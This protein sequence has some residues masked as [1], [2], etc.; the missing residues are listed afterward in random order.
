MNSLRIALFTYSTKPRG[1]VIHTLELA[2]ALHQLGHE[3]TV[4]ALDKDGCGFDRALSCRYQPV[5]AQP[6]SGDFD[7]VIQQR[8]QEFVSYLSQGQFVTQPPDCYHAQ[9]CLSANAL[10]ILRQQN[11]I[12]HFLRTIHHIDDFSSPYL[13]QCQDRSI[14]EPDFCLCVS[15]YWQQQIQERY[16]IEAARVINGVNLE[17]FSPQ[18]TRADFAL[19]DQLNLTGYPIYL[20]VGG[21]EPRK[22]SIR[23]LHAFAQVRTH[24]PQAQLVIAGGATLFDY[25]PYRDQFFAE[26][27]RLE[28]AI[29]S[30]LILPG[31]I[32]DAD[33]PKLYRLAQAFVFPSLKEGWG[34]VVLEAIASGLPVVISD[35]FPFTEFLSSQQALWVD[36]Q[37]VEAIAEAMVK[38]TKPKISRSLIEQTRTLCEQFSWQNSA[39]MHLEHYNT[40]LNHHTL[41]NHA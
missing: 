31:V 29:G 17:R 5:P 33:L 10:A 39:K 28:L 36:P 18:P 8:I 22:N 1:S 40:L 3:V 16:G 23:I 24:Y 13:Q 20:T 35:Q 37:G 25:Q 41:I 15:Q 38:V 12:P 7:Q 34:L 27:E 6:A 14:R 32:P 26:V 11:Q 2:E 21:I 4:Y 9:D 30:A 19:R